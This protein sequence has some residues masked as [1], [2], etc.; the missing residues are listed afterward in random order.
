MAWLHAKVLE[1]ENYWPREL[2][3]LRKALNDE[4]AARDAAAAKDGA[5]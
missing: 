1:R 2:A 5:Q 3:A 4:I